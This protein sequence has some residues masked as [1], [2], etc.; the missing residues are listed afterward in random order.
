MTAE[1]IIFA[2]NLTL[3]DAEHNVQ[4][5]HNARGKIMSIDSG[6]V[7]L[8]MK[9]EGSNVSGSILI[10]P[11]ISVERT[12]NLMK[13]KSTWGIF[14]EI[15]CIADNITITGATSFD[16]FN[17]MNNRTYIQSFR[18]AGA[19]TSNPFPP[20]LSQNYARTHIDNY[21]VENNVDLLEVMTSPIALVWTLIITAFISLSW[22]FKA[23]KIGGSET[24]PLAR[25]RCATLVCCLTL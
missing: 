4:N 2:G 1:S 14:Q 20:D 10:S 9:S 19:Y 25:A 15:G 12:L 23:R 3:E 13:M 5:F 18:Y 6:K 17:S 7:S 16:V 24:P 22:A 21:L 11:H 8:Y